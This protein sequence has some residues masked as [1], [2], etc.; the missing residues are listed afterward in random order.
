VWADPEGDYR[1]HG[2][3]GLKVDPAEG[4]VILQTADLSDYR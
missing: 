4:R 3:L 2:I 1:S